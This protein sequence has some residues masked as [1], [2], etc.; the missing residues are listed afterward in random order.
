MV[1]QFEMMKSEIDSYIKISVFIFSVLY[2]LRN[3]T[4]E[5]NNGGL[6]SKDKNHRHWEHVMVC[7]KL[8][9]LITFRQN[10]TKVS[11]FN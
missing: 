10:K 4:S 6:F 5:Y 11:S 9:N 2:F 3:G 8:T 7:K 1:R